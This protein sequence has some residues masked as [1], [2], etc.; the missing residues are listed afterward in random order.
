MAC[1]T[2][3]PTR[4]EELGRAALFA[5]GRGLVAFIAIAVMLS[6]PWQVA[7]PAGIF[8]M[9]VLRTTWWLLAYT[10]MALIRWYVVWKTRPYRAELGPAGRVGDPNAAWRQWLDTRCHTCGA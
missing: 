9:V 5:I 7:I 1:R 8:A 6:A 3:R 4:S 2:K 10:G